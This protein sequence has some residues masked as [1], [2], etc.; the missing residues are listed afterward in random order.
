MS[1]KLKI[2]ETTCVVQQRSKTPVQLNF[3]HE[4]RQLIAVWA[5]LPRRRRLHAARQRARKVIVRQVGEAGRHKGLIL[6]KI[7]ANAARELIRL[8]P[9]LLQ[10]REFRNPVGH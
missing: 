10:A 8:Q 3:S 1:C 4:F 5:P 6:A 7:L 9:Q 2:D